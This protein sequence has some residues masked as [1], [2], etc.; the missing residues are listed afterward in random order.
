[1]SRHQRALTLGELIRVVSECARN[2]HE[3][4]LAV[5]DLLQRGVV[6]RAR[7]AAILAA[8]RTVGLGHHKN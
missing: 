3:V 1:M 4:R 6:V 8:L 2:D 7:P 5:A